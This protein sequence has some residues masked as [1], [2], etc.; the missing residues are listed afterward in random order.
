MRK[1]ILNEAFGIL[2]LALLLI[3]QIAHTVYIF[4]RNSHYAHAWFSWCYAVGVD[5]AILI[6][7]VKGWIKTAV[8]YFIGTLAHNLVYQ[9]AP[10]STLSALL[11]CLMLSATIFSFSH[12]FFEHKKA[13]QRKPSVIEPQLTANQK[14]MLAA[15][16]AG[17]RFEAQPYRCPCC[18]EAFSSTKKLNGHISGHKQK[19]EW[20]PEE[21]ADWERGNE[22]RAALLNQ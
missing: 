1:F 15:S 19:G 11:I 8:A 6:F 20:L 12:L 13:D 10:N 22:Q 4:E 3:P 2:A 18:G 17:I 16:K 14:R 7:T 9:F 21:Y 5:L